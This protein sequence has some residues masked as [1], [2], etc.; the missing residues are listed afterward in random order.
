MTHKKLTCEELK[1]YF[2]HNG[3]YPDQFHLDNAMLRYRHFGDMIFKVYRGQLKNICYRTHL[4]F[5][6]EM[7]TPVAFKVNNVEFIFACML[8]DE[9][10][11]WESVYSYYDDAGHDAFGVVS[12]YLDKYHDQLLGRNYDIV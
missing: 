10:T 6:L 7:A 12:D 9:N 5:L 2:N 1:W 4:W 3:I 8:E 11:D